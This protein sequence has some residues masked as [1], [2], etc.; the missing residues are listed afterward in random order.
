MADYIDT[1]GT[2]PRN[3]HATA[4]AVT[5]TDRV[6]WGPILAGLF[7]ALSTLA[8][9]SVLGVAIGLTAWDAGDPGTAFG[10]GAGIWGIISTL[11]AFGVGGWVA[12]ATAA[13][14]G[15]TNGSINGAMV[16]AVAIPVMLFL[17]A[18]GLTSLAGTAAGAADQNPQI[19]AYPQSPADTGAA[20]E[21]QAADEMAD[22]AAWSAWGTLIAL[23][24]GL[25]AA[26]GG[27]YLGARK[28][29]DATRTAPP[30]VA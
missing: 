14:R 9:L 4:T 27:G 18:G 6:R 12:A 13:V 10:I 23:L 7:A 8:L 28:L 24:L 25:A 15:E 30:A 3:A 19:M 21:G 2:A 11:I 1:P 16:W 5:P 29:G 17:A 20:M 22:N 26:A